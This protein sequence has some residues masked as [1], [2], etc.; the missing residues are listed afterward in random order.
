MAKGSQQFTNSWLGGLTACSCCGH[1][2]YRKNPETGRMKMFKD[3]IGQTGS[4]VQYANEADLVGR[5]YPYA[6]CVECCKA[7]TRRVS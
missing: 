7:R 1:E 5:S 4:R 3:E 2:F 6:Y